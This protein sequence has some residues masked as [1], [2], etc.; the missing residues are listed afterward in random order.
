MTGLSLTVEIRHAFCAVV[1]GFFHL[2]LFGMLNAAVCVN[3][4]V[5]TAAIKTTIDFVV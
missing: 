4:L 3:D 2:A 5:N 1:L